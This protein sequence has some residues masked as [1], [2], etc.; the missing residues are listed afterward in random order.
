[1]PASVSILS[2]HGHIKHSPVSLQGNG[3][4]NG[5]S[6]EKGNPPK[7]S[8]VQELVVESRV[9]TDVEFV[10]ILDQTLEGG[11]CWLARSLTFSQNGQSTSQKN[12]QIC[13]TYTRA[14]VLVMLENASNGSASYL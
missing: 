2:G 12:R 4:E 11:F 9:S 14:M 7:Q 3:F 6:R 1:M 8:S 13:K 5:P 10:K